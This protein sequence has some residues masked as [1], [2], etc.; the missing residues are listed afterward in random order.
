M[1]QCGMCEMGPPVRQS[2]PG[3]K[4]SY[5]SF[6]P[7]MFALEQQCRDAGPGLVRLLQ[8]QPGAWRLLFRKEE[9]VTMSKAR[10][11]EVVFA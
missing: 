9:H 5:P 6:G 4:S 11:C 1:F 8:G 3:P 7:A 10:Q 2:W